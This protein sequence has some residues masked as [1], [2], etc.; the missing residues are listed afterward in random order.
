VWIAPLLT[1]HWVT[2]AFT[3]MLALA[4]LVLVW[5]SIKQH[6]DAVDALEAT[7][8]LA[9]ATENAARDRRHTE[10]AGFILKMDEK[11]DQSRF[12]K[13]TDDIQSHNGNFHLPKYPNATDADVDEYISVFDDIGSFITQNLIES[14]MAYDDFSYDIEK[15]WCNV[16]VQE[17]IRDERANDKSKTAQSDPAYGDFE[18][19]AKEYLKTDGL[20]CK[21]VDSATSPTKKKMIKR[22]RAR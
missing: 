18:K 13:I 5:T 12:D 10:S 1:P 19:L 21:E 22:N 8:R 16:T 4:T 14:K 20:S 2:A 3:A 6:G 15:A 9:T 7:N 17:T 11:L